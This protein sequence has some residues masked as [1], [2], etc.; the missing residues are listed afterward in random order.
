MVLVSNLKFY[1]SLSSN[2]QIDNEEYG[3]ALALAHT[4]ELDSDLVY[5]RQWRKVPATV[6]SI[7]DYL[8]SML[9]T[10]QFL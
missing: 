4:Y 2:N 5:Q 6:E 1:I 9:K 7:H 10:S 3:E 8:V